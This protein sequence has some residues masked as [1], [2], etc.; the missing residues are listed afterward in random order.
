MAGEGRAVISSWRMLCEIVM[1]SVVT[2]PEESNAVNWEIN[3]A[4]LIP[5][6]ESVSISVKARTLVSLAR[7]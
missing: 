6:E 7:T 5:T 1:M 2:T 3:R 4:K